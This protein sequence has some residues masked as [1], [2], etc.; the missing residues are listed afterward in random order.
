MSKTK[1]LII[2]LN[3][4]KKL[5][6]FNY[7]KTMSYYWNSP[8]ADV[9]IRNFGRFKIGKLYKDVDRMYVLCIGKEFNHGSCILTFL[10]CD[11]MKKII[12]VHPSS[13]ITYYQKWDQL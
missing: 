6:E 11:G 2:V 3:T 7:L 8:L 12:E 5:Y 10:C 9:K 13:T 1:L 4:N